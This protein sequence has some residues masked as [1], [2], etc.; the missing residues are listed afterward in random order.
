MSARHIAEQSSCENDEFALP[1]PEPIELGTAA[2]AA[3]AGGI[4]RPGLCT[5]CGIMQPFPVTYLS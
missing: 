3:V 2:A 4:I 5:T 1:L